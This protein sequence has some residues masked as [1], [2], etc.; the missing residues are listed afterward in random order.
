MRTALRI[1][2]A[3]CLAAGLVGLAAAQEPTQRLPMERPDFEFPTIDGYEVLV[4]DFHIHT[5]HSDGV[6]PSRER[7][8]E[9]YLAGYDAI[10]LTDHGSVAA[11]AETKALAD[12]LG[13]VFVRGLESGINGQEHY[14]LLGV[15]EEYVPQDSH[16]WAETPEQ[17]QETGRVYYR[18]KL[19]QVRNSGG[20]ALYAHPHH[21]W[22][23]CSQ[24]AYE[25]GSRR[26]E[27]LNSCTTEGGARVDL[28][29]AAYPST[30]STGAWRRATAGASPPAWLYGARRAPGRRLLLV[31]A[32]TPEAII[33]AL[34][35]GGH[36][37]GS[38][39][40]ARWPGSP[41]CSGRRGDPRALCDDVTLSMDR[42]SGGSRPG[43]P[44]A[45]EPR[46]RDAVRRVQAGGVATEELARAARSILSC[47]TQGPHRMTVE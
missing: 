46:G 5:N 8:L 2:F 3:L 17:A 44:H 33:E 1:C 39:T 18:D 37:P 23:E 11:Y 45:A 20:I 16:N 43:A 12:E 7:V 42:A 19:E 27:V 36:W 30:A 40:V 13:L 47:T 35:E 34:R 24:W 4:G 41:R 29:R 22:R 6:L 26:C 14:V 25:Q 9:S 31:D 38:P 15:G 32:A 28:R 10:A 21:G